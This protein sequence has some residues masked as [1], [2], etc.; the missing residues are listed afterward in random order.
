MRELVEPVQHGVDRGAPRRDL[1]RALLLL[2]LLGDL[3]QAEPPQHGSA[4]PWP[5][6]VTMITEKVRNRI[7]FRSGN[8][9]PSAVA[10]G[11]ASAAASETMPRTPVK[12]SAKGNFHGGSGSALRIAGNSQR[13][14]RSP[15]TSR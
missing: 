1:G 10:N 2:L 11:I 4:R 9:A 13:A 3:A 5:T 14:D 6:S 12:A 7:R 8:G 15:D